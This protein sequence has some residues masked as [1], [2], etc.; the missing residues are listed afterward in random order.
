[1]PLQSRSMPSKDQNGR[2]P[3]T[4]NRAVWQK[5]YENDKDSQIRK[6]Q[7]KT[8]NSSPEQV[9]RERETEN[10]VTRE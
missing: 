3:V 7:V 9:E 6:K 8:A 5:S 2:H 1:M 10:S 4:A